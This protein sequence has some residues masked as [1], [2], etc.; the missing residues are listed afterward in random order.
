[1][2]LAALCVYLEDGG[3]IFFVQTR[4]GRGGRAFACLKFRSMCID[5]EQ[6]LEAHF[7]EHPAD[8][9][10]YARSRK[11]RADPR[12]TRVGRFLRRYS[13]DEL[14]QFLNVLIGDMSLVGPRPIMMGEAKAYG[15]R[16]G[17]YC[18]V[19]PGVTGLWQVTGRSHTTF[20]S[21]VAM[22]ALYL[23]SKS[24]R[25]DLKIL[26]ATLPVVIRATGSY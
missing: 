1:M 8:R 19:R 23:R 14:P 11:L 6:R 13:I 26:L 21:R 2:V 16:L 5:A 25:L 10:E 24:L 9:I 4:M 18:S 22:D 12:V 7:G 17:L 20:R 15:Y 3:P